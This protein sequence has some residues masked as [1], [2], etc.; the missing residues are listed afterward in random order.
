M[1]RIRDFY[2]Y[3][4]YK[5]T[6]TLHPEAPNAGEKEPERGQWSAVTQRST[7]VFT[8]IIDSGL[9]HLQ[10]KRFDPDSGQTLRLE[11]ARS[12]TKVSTKPK[13]QQHPHLHH[14]H[15]QHQQLL[16][17]QQQQQQLS[18]GRTALLHQQLVARTIHTL[19]HHTAIS[20]NSRISIQDKTGMMVLPQFCDR[21]E[22]I[23]HYVQ[24]TVHSIV[25][26]DK[27]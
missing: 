26:M 19:H 25:V 2:D 20:S 16:I 1:E 17:Q 23:R 11:Y 22:C 12:N 7:M 5:F 10:G 24:C 21:I 27:S 13:P 9:F 4:L 18:V 8:V 6:F 15:H 14:H 3:A